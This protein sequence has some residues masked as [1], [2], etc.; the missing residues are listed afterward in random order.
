[1]PPLLWIKQLVVSITAGDDKTFGLI[2]GEI[3]QGSF[4][5]AFLGIVV[6]SSIATHKL[7]LGGMT[8]Y[9]TYSHRLPRRRGV[10]DF[11]H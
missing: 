3:I 7:C 10:V 6:V 1:M 8:Q 4:E 9:N 5:I 11:L 2:L